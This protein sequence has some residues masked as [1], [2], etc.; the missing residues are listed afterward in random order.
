V[1]SQF[2]HKLLGSGFISNA[3]AQ[4]D[5]LYILIKVESLSIGKLFFQVWEL[6]PSIQFLE[7]LLIEFH[8]GVSE[9]ISVG[10][11]V[12]MSVGISVGISEGTSVKV[13]VGVNVGVSVSVGMSV[14][15]SVGVS[16]QVSD[17]VV[18]KLG[19]GVAGRLVAVTTT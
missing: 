3:T 10:M 9:G 13:D 19:R 11:S 2:F 12:G 6:G 5:N 7:K 18:V 16:V 15:V 1:D 14:G 4:E 17:G 8:V